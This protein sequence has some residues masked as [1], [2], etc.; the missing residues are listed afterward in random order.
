MVESFE[1]TFSFLSVLRKT[2]NNRD[3]SFGVGEMGRVYNLG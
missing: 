2:E 1:R 3:C